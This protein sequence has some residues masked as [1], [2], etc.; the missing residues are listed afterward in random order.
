M[1]LH[2]FNNYIHKVS[3]L[4]LKLCIFLNKSFCYDLF[5]LLQWAFDRK[6]THLLSVVP[7]LPVLSIKMFD[8]MEERKQQASLK[9]ALRPEMCLATLSSAFTS[10]TLG[11]C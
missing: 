5:L 4:S 11:S 10:T 8:E 6:M 2:P 9:K 7:F 1:Y 3:T